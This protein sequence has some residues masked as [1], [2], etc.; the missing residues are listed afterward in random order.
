MLTTIPNL[1]NNLSAS[2]MVPEL[3][4]GVILDYTINCSTSTGDEVN[5]FVVGGMVTDTTLGNLLPY[6]TYTCTISARTRAGQGGLSGPQTAT[7]DE[8]GK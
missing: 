1:P 7:T 3:A 8:D 6:T 5:S 2:W 4:N